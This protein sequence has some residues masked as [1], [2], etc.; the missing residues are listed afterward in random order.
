MILA[1]KICLLIMCCAFYL[2]A[3]GAKTEKQTYISGGVGTV[4]A[5]ILVI[6]LKLL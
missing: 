2:S 5:V 3:L 4:I 1:T 6:A